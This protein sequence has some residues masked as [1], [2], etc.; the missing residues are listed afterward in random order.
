MPSLYGRSYTRRELEAHVGDVSQI[1]SVTA[2]R[3]ADGFEDG[4]PAVD[5]RT[6]TGFEFTVLPGRGLD[7]SRASL[8]GRSLAWRSAQTDRH[9][10]HYEPEG[11]GWLRSFAGGL[12]ATCGTL[13]HGA[14]CVDGAESLGLH[15]RI[16]NTPAT[17]VRWD[18]EWQGD[19]Y[20]LSVEGRLREA[21]VFGDNVAMSRRIEARLGE[22]RLVIVDTV[23]NLG[24]APAPH[25]MLYHVNLGFPVVAEGARIVAP[26]AEARPR[27]A[28]ATEGGEHWNR[29]EGP[30]PGYREKCY[31][32]TMRSAAD[33][34]VTAAVVN[35]GCDGGRGLAVYVRYRQA[36]LPLFTE[37]KMMG[38]GVYV[39]GLEPCNA[40]VMG[41]PVE[42][43]AGRLQML[44]PGERRC[45]RVEIGAAA[46]PEA[47]AEVERLAEGVR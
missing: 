26:S 42:R 20:V 28:D 11:L 25:M 33:G 34:T 35:P 31:F 13:W 3:L 16:G 45:Y 41:R 9:P 23:E 5:F 21:V 12:L 44:Q 27:D 43:E 30:T 6:G 8:A 17:N 18:A 7:I 19:D 37:W 15:G 29:I 47:L 38:Q 2:C 32:H 14:P 40:L 39:V 22:S 10:A 1:A 24:F 36:E 46:G 4:A